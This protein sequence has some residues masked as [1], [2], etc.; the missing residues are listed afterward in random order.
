[1]WSNETAIEIDAT[2]DRIWSCFSDV[3][4]WPEWNAGIE[5]IELLGPFERGSRFIM[6]PPEME[7]LETELVE[8]TPDAGFTD[9]TELGENAVRV[10]HLI[11]P[12]TGGV[13][14]IYRA[15]VSGPQAA[16]IGPMVTSDFAD[17]LAALKRKVEAG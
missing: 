17:V 15:T 1:M 13:R 12:M 2:P 7:P 16:E 5:S 4:G 11:E 3:A 6:K 9:L 10:E 8:V 14:V